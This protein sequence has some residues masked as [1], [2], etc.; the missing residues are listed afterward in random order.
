MEQVTEYAVKEFD[1]PLIGYNSGLENEELK[2]FLAKPVPIYTGF[3]S[4][5][6]P[7]HSLLFRIDLSGASLFPSSGIWYQKLLGYYGINCNIRLR[8]QLNANPFQCGLLRMVYIPCHGDTGNK[9]F[10]HTS[11]PVL[12]S[13]LPGIVYDVNCNKE[14][15]LVIPFKHVVT[16]YQL[17]TKLGKWGTVYCYYYT[18]FQNSTGAS[19][20][21]YT[22]WA[23]L[24]EITL[25]G[26][27]LPIIMQAGKRKVKVKKAKQQT[28]V[29]TE[30]TQA[31]GPV[32]SFIDSAIPYVDALA[33]VP[34]LSS[35]ATPV[36]WIASGISE[37][38]S[39][40]GWSKPINSEI[41]TR[42]R[43]TY[44]EDLNNAN[45]ASNAIPLAVSRVNKIEIEPDLTWSDQDEMCIRYVAGRS[46]Y[47]S[48][49]NWTSGLTIGS[50]L[51]NVRVGPGFMA[52]YVGG[53]THCTPVGYLSKL[54]GMWR[55]SMCFRFRFAKTDYHTGRVIVSFAPLPTYQ[56]S[57]T[58]S[59]ADTNYL[60]REVVDLT[61]GSEFCFTIPY[62]QIAPYLLINQ[63]TG[64]LNVKIL[65]PLTHPAVVS[66]NVYCNVEVWGGDDIEFAFPR[67]SDFAFNALV[68]QSGD[69]VVA[70]GCS[71][72]SKV[73][74]NATITEDLGSL[75]AR[76]C[77][78]ERVTSLKQ[79]IMRQS[80]FPLPD[81][82]ST[83]GNPVGFK[84]HVFLSA[85]VPTPDN[86]S[87]IAPLYTFA[88]GSIVL[89][90]INPITPD[91][92]FGG[93]INACNRSENTVIP[94]GTTLA[95]FN[96][97]NNE[98]FLFEESSFGP[99]QVAIPMNTQGT[100]TLITP[101][102]GN[103]VTDVDP[104][105]TSRSYVFRMSETGLSPTTTFLRGGADDFYCS[106][107]I[108]VPSM[109]GAVTSD[110]DTYQ[111]F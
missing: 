41:P 26:P 101:F 33:E 70:K 36:S 35:I 93:L 24:E 111:T 28:P 17:S 5:V 109:I 76:M 67:D 45:S 98:S 22:L 89:T 61:Q 6:A 105:F 11:G 9:T 32:Q 97:C 88:R 60:L 106:L 15:D 12:Y 48:N 74:G 63:A 95:K 51:Y 42:M 21:D 110:I 56:T 85:P 55:G 108:G 99:V 68:A 91:A 31:A 13:Q 7:V 102:D 82:N 104:A 107:F 57:V 62:Y 103:N 53:N 52:T 39:W 96:N 14:V 59:L 18:P 65:N 83:P 49:F 80:Y 90:A 81:P 69:R 79:L 92:R 77:I 94:M 19:L 84:P 37:V 40:F 30:E 16:Q 86:I 38:C 3:L 34:F 2:A 27:A 58:L 87:K 29:Q 8:L 44:F 75:Q 1:H 73:I 54:F 47:I 43:R 25:T 64:I 46:A 50:D 23:S 72:A 71:I 100:A 78:G 66:S 10:D 4:D 20:P